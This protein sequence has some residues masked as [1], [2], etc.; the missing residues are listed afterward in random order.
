[1]KLR[2]IVITATENTHRGIEILYTDRYEADVKDKHLEALEFEEIV[3][4][5]DNE[6]DSSPTVSL[7]GH[8]YWGSVTRYGQPYTTISEQDKLYVPG[9]SVAQAHSQ[10]KELLKRRY[11]ATRQIF[12][13]DVSKIVKASTAAPKW[14][15]S[16]LSNLFRMQYAD[17]PC[18]GMTV[19]ELEAVM[20]EFYNN[21]GGL[22]DKIV[23]CLW[24][25]VPEIQTAD[26]VQLDIDPRPDTPDYQFIIDDLVIFIDVD[27]NG[28]PFVT[29]W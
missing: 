4:L 14:T 18:V 25:E 17:D 21:I 8:Y 26:N 10:L 11:G 15:P 1:M 22:R 2:R 23:D 7:P 29:E 6:L 13:V 19:K 20:D 24:N 3:R 16:R 12:D 5:I 27:G 9:I 28:E